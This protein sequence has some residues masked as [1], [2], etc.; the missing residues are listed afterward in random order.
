MTT[1]TSNPNL[2][3]RDLTDSQIISEYAWLMERDRFWTAPS[4]ERRT[5]LNKEAVRRG[6]GNLATYPPTPA[7][8]VSEPT[9]IVW[10]V[11][12]EPRTGTVASL[13]LSLAAAERCGEEDMIG[14]VA[15]VAVPQRLIWPNRE[16]G[17]G[18][19]RFYDG[20]GLTPRMIRLARMPYDEDD[21]AT[22]T[23]SVD[24]LDET[25]QYRIDGRS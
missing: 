21:F 3:P 25:G 2:D 16:R 13:A 6:L 5:A 22:V 7:A 20:H 1:T 10:I 24:G 18:G 23:V 11:D 19:S 4:S 12:G 8:P 15:Y 17:P 9:I 14:R